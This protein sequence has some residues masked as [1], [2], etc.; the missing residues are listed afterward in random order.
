MTQTNKVKKTDAQ[1][2]YSIYTNSDL[3]QYNYLLKIIYEKA[4]LGINEITVS[5]KLASVTIHKLKS[6]G[7]AVDIKSGW[8]DDEYIISFN[9][10]M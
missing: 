5:Y 10:N 4:A 2:A 8:E 3:H 6:E 7:F 1:K 9:K